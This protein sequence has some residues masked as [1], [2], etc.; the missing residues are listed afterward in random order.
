LLRRL[1]FDGLNARQ[2]RPCSL[3]GG[4]H[5]TGEQ[6]PFAQAEFL[7]KRGGDVRVGLLGDIVTSGVAKKAV[8]LGVHFK[9]ALGRLVVAGHR[10]L[11]EGTRA[12]G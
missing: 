11:R 1:A 3:A 5:G 2:T 12:R 9:H 4:V 6:K 7:N 8:S 10:F